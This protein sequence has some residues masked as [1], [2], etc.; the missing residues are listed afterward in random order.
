MSSSTADILQKALTSETGE[1]RVAAFTELFQLCQNKLSI[2]HDSARQ[3]LNELAQHSNDLNMLNVLGEI[4]G[5]GQ[6]IELE[7]SNDHFGKIIEELNG[8]ENTGHLIHFKNT[9]TAASLQAKVGKIEAAQLQIQ[10]LSM[11]EYGIEAGGRQSN[12]G[13][14]KQQFEAQLNLL[15]KQVQLLAAQGKEKDAAQLVHQLIDAEIEMEVPAL[16]QRKW[17]PQVLKISQLFYQL[18]STCEVL[19]DA[20]KSEISERVELLRNEKF[21]GSIA[22]CREIVL[23]LKSHGGSTTQ[24]RPLADF[25]LGI[26]LTRVGKSEPLLL[27]EAIGYFEKAVHGGYALATTEIAEINELISDKFMEVVKDATLLKVCGRSEKFFMLKRVET[28]YKWAIEAGHPEARLAYLT[29]LVAEKQDA[30]AEYELATL[31][32]NGSETPFPKRDIVK[33]QQLLNSAAK[34]GHVGAAEHLDKNGKMC[35][36]VL[37]IEAARD[38]EMLAIDAMRQHKQRGILNRSD[39]THLDEAIARYLSVINFFYDNQIE[40]LLDDQTKIAYFECA[41]ER[42]DAKV[43]IALGKIRLGKVTSLS[44]AQ[45]QNTIALLEKA[46]HSADND[47]K[48]KAH[49]V[50]GEFCGEV[51]LK[52]PGDSTA[53]KLKRKALKHYKQAIELGNKAASP[54]ELSFIKK[55]IA[56]GPAPSLTEKS[57]IIIRLKEIVNSAHQVIGNEVARDGALMLLTHYSFYIPQ[58]WEFLDPKVEANKYEKIARKLTDE[59]D[60]ENS[61]TTLFVNAISQ[62]PVKETDMPL[63]NRGKETIAES[64]EKVVTTLEQAELDE[65]LAIKAQQKK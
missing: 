10:I 31:Y 37:S 50:L 45:E 12:S 17:T 65:E 54:L 7:L 52:L 28:L 46:T 36:K 56:S 11:K 25:H 38:A 27:K 5:D 41:S 26:Y 39:T 6:F 33:A 51:F 24:A 59:I 32:L 60:S 15:L 57:T 62:Q 21:G 1:E 63:I 55:L 61:Q 14:S 22:I 53:I 20:C 19:S 30:N 49:L 16:L 42:G 64:K 4:Y 29:F 47:V 13:E 48:A 34:K 2:M 23:R 9:E 44:K 8:L 35:F 40:Y 43:Q 18:L 3:A 58:P